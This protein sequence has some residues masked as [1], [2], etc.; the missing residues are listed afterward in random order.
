MPTLLCA[1]PSQHLCKL[2]ARALGADGLR[3]VIAHDGEAALELLR[4]R[5]P[6]VAILDVALPLRDGLAVLE[7]MRTS[8]SPAA[9]VPVILWSD[10]VCSAD[11]VE[12]ARKLGASALLRKPVPIDA[13]V[14]RVAKLLARERDARATDP[15]RSRRVAAL[16]GSLDEVPFPALL[17]QAHGLRASGVLQLRSGEKRKEIEL[18]DGRPSAV[19][20]NL[21]TE[22]L[23][24]WLMHSGRIEPA[25]LA[26]SAR[27]LLRGEGLQGQILVGMQVLSAEDLAAALREQAEEKLFEVFE[28]TSGAFALA[29]GAQLARASALPLVRST[30]DVISQGIRTRAPLARIDALLAAHAHNS[31][32]PSANP[33]YS[34]Q[35]VELGDA[36]RKMLEACAKGPSMKAVLTKTE[37]VR[38]VAYALLEMGLLELR[39]GDLFRQGLPAPVVRLHAATKPPSA[40]AASPRPAPA[41]PAAPTRARVAEPAPPPAPAPAEDHSHY[42]ADHEQRT[43]LTAL[44]GRLGH[45][46]PFVKLGIGSDASDD[47]IRSAY[48][49]LAKETHP[50][51]YANASHAARELAEQAFREVTRAYEM[52]SDPARL[53]TYRADPLRDRREAQALDEA[54]RAI[55]AERE[56][57]R[58]EARLRSHDWSGALAHFE[59]AV[60]L[61]PDEGEYLAYCGWAYY[62][63]HG[64]DDD[65]FRHAF[66][67]VK[68]GAKLAPERE[69]PYL[70]LGRLCQAAGRLELAERMFTKAVG[71]RPDSIEALREL[72]LLQMRRPKRGLLGRLLG[73]KGAKPR[74]RSPKRD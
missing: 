56:F 69:K 10:A 66:A 33:F 53:A 30:A 4:E 7:S 67:L 24:E 46:S 55:S 74:G 13:L 73:S 17:H 71:C 26:E 9:T 43:A 15:H 16:R 68:K 11:Q 20:S 42:A 23:G 8:A 5:K 28:W 18:R 65:V 27:R 61:Y 35:D 50:D 22:R 1:D 37:R 12:R 59:R 3:V 58:G 49:R 29:L 57:Q 45:P 31:L 52:L 41:K 44:L 51:R 48:M 60:E 25:V 63:T 14:A 40:A 19:R 21:P 38:R 2:L 36:E 34:F 64:H 39:E 72:R 32:V 47:A 54:Q 62:L 6:D 70:F